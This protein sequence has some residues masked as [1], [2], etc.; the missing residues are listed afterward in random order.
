MQDKH[1]L[2]KAPCAL[3]EKEIKKK[4]LNKGPCL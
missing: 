3:R 1:R 4:K 2:N